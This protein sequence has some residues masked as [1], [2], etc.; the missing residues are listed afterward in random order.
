MALSESGRRVAIVAGGRTPFARAGTTLR[1]VSAIELGKIAVRE[2]VHRTNL[3]VDALDLLV[4]GTVIP[5]VLA[6]N[7]ARE[8]ALMPLLPKRAQAWSV[9]RAC[10]SA[11]SRASGRGTSFPSLRPSPS[12]RRARRWGSR[13]RRWRS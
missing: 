13:R 9:S 12:P 5:S 4:F 2:L 6:P 1:G 7:I 8:V 11:N 10:A 3:D